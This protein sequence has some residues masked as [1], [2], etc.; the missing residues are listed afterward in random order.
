MPKEERAGNST[1]KD[2]VGRSRTQRHPRSRER[3]EGSGDPSVGS[4][5]RSSEA[6]P[7]RC[8]ASAN[9]TQQKHVGLWL[10]CNILKT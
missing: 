9:H 8:W 1:E 3:R 7:V 2:Q 10:L 4:R 6:G 5:V